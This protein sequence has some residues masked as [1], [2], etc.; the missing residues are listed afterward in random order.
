MVDNIQ[1]VKIRSTVLVYS[2]DI[3]VEYASPELDRS[4]N[5]GEY[6]CPQCG[7]DNTCCIDPKQ[8]PHGCF[9]LDCDLLWEYKLMEEY[10]E[11]GGD[12]DEH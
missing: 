12:E 11:E 10:E 9:C 5:H 3:V 6:E 2:I 7:S 1:I 4:Y 8:E